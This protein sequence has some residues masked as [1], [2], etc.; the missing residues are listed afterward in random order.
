MDWKIIWD[1]AFVTGAV[2]GF[3]T[4]AVVDFGE[5]RSRKDFDQARTYEWG[6]AA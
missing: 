5:F 3:V 6:L 1:S 4:T 2:S